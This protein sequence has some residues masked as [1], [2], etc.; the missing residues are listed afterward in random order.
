[1][2]LSSPSV[3]FKTVFLFLDFHL[4]PQVQLYPCI[5]I[6]C[7]CLLTHMLMNS[8]K[9]SGLNVVILFILNF[10]IRSLTD[11]HTSSPLIILYMYV[12]IYTHLATRTH[13][14]VSPRLCI[15]TCFLIFLWVMLFVLSSDSNNY[16]S[17]VII[18]CCLKTE[19]SNSQII[20][21][22]I[23]A[24]SCYLTKS[25]TTNVHQ[26]WHT[27]NKVSM[28]LFMYLYLNIYLSLCIYVCVHIY[29]CKQKF[30]SVIWFFFI[31]IVLNSGYSAS[32]NEGRV[33]GKNWA[34]WMPGMYMFS[35]LYKWC[36]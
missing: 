17:A 31:E 10:F 36:C 26:L 21:V 24:V 9:A 6:I 15:D 29:I 30:E 32:K 5:Q 34:T 35:N 3:A 33:S 8:S 7:M 2:L 20:K 4:F 16:S 1:M 11:K 22:V 23:F 13:K 27:H 28:Y 25:L 14:Y 12:S 18:S 19:S